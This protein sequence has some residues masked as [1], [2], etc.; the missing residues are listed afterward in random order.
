MFKKID[1][2]VILVVLILVGAVTV[3]AGSLTPPGAP[4]N[5]MYT[6]TDIFNL[7]AG[8]T[9]TLGSGTIPTTPSSVSPSFKT[10]TEIYDAIAAQIANLSNEKIANGVSAFGFTGTLLGDTDAAKVLTSATYPGSYYDFNL[11]ASNVLAGVTFGVGLMGTALGAQLIKTNQA[12]CYDAAGS[13]I[14][15]GGTGQDGESLRGAARSYTDRMNGT[16]IDNNT[17]L[18]WQKQDNSQTYT[19]VNALAYCNANMAGLVGPS[20]RLPNVYELYSLVDFGVA[21]A[22]YI[23]GTLFPATQGNYWSATTHPV[24]KTNAMIVDFSSG[25]ATTSDK[26]SSYY[27][28]CVREQIGY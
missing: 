20:W 18:I 4:A 19:W 15:C 27:F 14:D 6:M 11:T 1:T 5:T 9:A 21:S 26:A 25:V 7:S 12:I 10:L 17:G 3:Y 24:T 16:I 23:N 8:T 28:R 2:L 22:P 13:V